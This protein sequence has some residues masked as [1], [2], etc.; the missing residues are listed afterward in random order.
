MPRGVYASLVF[1]AVLVIAAVSIANP[2][3]NETSDVVVEDFG[4]KIILLTNARLCDGKDYWI[5]ALTD[6]KLV[7]M[8]NRFF[9]RGKVWVSPR[10]PELEYSR[11][12]EKGIAWDDVATFRLFTPEQ[13]KVYDQD[14]ESEA[15]PDT[16]PTEAP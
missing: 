14:E 5:D 1:A 10:Q 6:A 2:K 7:Q 11:G 9:V 13:M 12:L 4:N 3:V 15:K 16:S 8:G